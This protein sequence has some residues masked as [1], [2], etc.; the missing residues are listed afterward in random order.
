MMFQNPELQFC[1]DTVQN[2]LIFCLENI[3]TPPEEI[4]G[5]LDRALAFCDISHLK[6]RTLLSLSGGER[7]KRCV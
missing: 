5:R 2:E 6:K 4:P 1:M 3:C 7:Q